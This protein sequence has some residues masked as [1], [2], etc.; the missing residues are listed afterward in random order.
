MP[1]TSRFNVNR[2]TQKC[3]CNRNRH[4]HP[5]LEQPSW[6]FQVSDGKVVAVPHLEVLQRGWPVL[7]RGL[8]AAVEEKPE[9]QPSQPL[10]PHDILYRLVEIPGKVKGREAVGEIDAGEG[11]VEPAS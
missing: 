4:P 9:G 8:D 5:H 10:R 2:F 3:P 6:P 11:L 1:T 7:S